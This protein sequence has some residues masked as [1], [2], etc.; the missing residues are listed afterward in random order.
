MC[1]NWRERK[2]EESNQ[3]DEVQKQNIGNED[4]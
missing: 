3:G 2:R 4:E 1:R